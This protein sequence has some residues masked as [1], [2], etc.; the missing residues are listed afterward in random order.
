VVVW[1]ADTT[2]NSNNTPMRQKRGGI[3]MTFLVSFVLSILG[4]R[5]HTASIDSFGSIE[6]EYGRR[7]IVRRILPKVTTISAFRSL[8]FDFSPHW[9]LTKSASTGS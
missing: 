3:S 5:L 8:E 4:D 9:L 1:A 2:V 7:K 6:G